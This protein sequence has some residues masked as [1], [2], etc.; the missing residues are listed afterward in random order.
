MQYAKEDAALLV[1]IMF[2]IPT[3]SDCNHKGCGL[4]EL[5]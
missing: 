2:C 5:A 1:A 4:Q 3:Y